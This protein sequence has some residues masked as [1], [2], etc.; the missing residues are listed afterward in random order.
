MAKKKAQ[1]ISM[2]VIIIAALALIVLVVLL[3]IF[4]GRMGIFGKGLNTCKG[5]CVTRAEECGDKAAIPTDNCNDKGKD[6]K[7]CCLEIS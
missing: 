6:Y 7:Y 1:G 4:T 2:N 3:V 5:S